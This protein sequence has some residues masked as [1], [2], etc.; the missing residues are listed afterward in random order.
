MRNGLF[1]FIGKNPI[2]SIKYW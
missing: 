2:K 1:K